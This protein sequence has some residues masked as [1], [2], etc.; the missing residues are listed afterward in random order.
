MS[1]GQ[2]DYVKSNAYGQTVDLHR[3]ERP[4]QMNFE[5][6]PG[7]LAS[8]LDP[9]DHPGLA[10]RAA[11]GAP[12]TDDPVVVDLLGRIALTTQGR[13][14]QTQ[15]VSIALTQASTML[16]RLVA[17]SLPMEEVPSAIEHGAYTFT[18]TPQDNGDVTVR[19]RPAAVMPFDREL[20]LTVSKEG[21]ITTDD[22]W[23]QAR[24]SAAQNPA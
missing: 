22:F 18:V 21:T 17:E 13:E 20:Q 10:Q 9:N 19:V 23:A 8:T 12:G 15:G 3:W 16:F 4:T 5:A 1:V 2:A 24:M 11:G 14:A 7:Q 6:A